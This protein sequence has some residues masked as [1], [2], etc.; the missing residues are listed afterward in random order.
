M[1]A[2]RDAAV[3]GFEGEGSRREMR[4]RRGEEVDAVEGF[5]EVPGGAEG[6]SEMKAT[7]G[8]AMYESV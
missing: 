7:K 5:V 2:W 6:C 4:R 8:S 1:C 3:R